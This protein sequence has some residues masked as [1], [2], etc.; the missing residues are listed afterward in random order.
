[1]SFTQTSKDF[2]K[3]FWFLLW[4][5]ETWK[6]WIFSVVVLFIFIKFIFFPGLS[7]VTG[8]QL[9]L[10]IVESCSMYH[11][12]GTW[13]LTNFNFWWQKHESKYSP[14]GITSFS[15]F[16]LHNG[17]NKGDILFMTGANP[18][19]LKVGD[20][21]LFQAGL[22]NPVIHRI[23]KIE[24]DSS[25][26]KRIFSTEGDNNNGQLPL[27]QKIT[28]EQIVGKAQF[29]VAPYLGWVKL[30]FYEFQRPDYEKGFCKEN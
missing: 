3:K 20:I 18:N 27:E 7:F 16:K 2:F 11:D 14:F 22:T 10:A 9:P 29:K 6:G 26:G 17:F 5:D 13:P 23:V 15:N 28:E 21:I 8:T 25:T 19:T 1:M 12:G 4:K 30:I 24:T